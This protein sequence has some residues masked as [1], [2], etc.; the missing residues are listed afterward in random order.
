MACKAWRRPYQ[1]RWKKLTR[2]SEQMRAR[3]EPIL[4]AGKPRRVRAIPK[5]RQ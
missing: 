3:W 5:L 1:K 2:P 4:D